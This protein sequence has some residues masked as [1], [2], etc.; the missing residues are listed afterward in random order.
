MRHND[1]G[2][3]RMTQKHSLHIRLAKWRL[4]DLRERL[5][6]CSRGF[7]SVRLLVH[8]HRLPHFLRRFSPLQSESPE[9]TA[10]IFAVFPRPSKS[11]N[12]YQRCC[13]ANW[14]IADV[15]QD[16]FDV[17]RMSTTTENVPSGLT[18]LQ[19]SKSHF[20]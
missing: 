7:R 13:L 2:Q 12:I 19:A 20:L 10:L 11:F 1:P 16:A 8:R 9:Q 6:N 4:S 3:Y 14:A 15:G 18:F 17:E 5:T